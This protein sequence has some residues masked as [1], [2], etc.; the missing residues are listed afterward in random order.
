MEV[1]SVMIHGTDI[2][3][4]VRIIDKSKRAFDISVESTKALEMVLQKD[5][6][7]CKHNCARTKSVFYSLWIM[8]FKLHGA[9]P[10]ARLNALFM[11][12][13]MALAFELVLTLIFLIH[14]F[15]P[16]TSVWTIGFAYLF[17]LPG[18]TLIAP[19]WGLWSTVMGSPWMMKIWSTMNTTMIILNYPLTILMLWYVQDQV[20]YTAV[21]LLLIFNKMSLSFYG[22]KVRQHF[23]NPGYAKTLEKMQVTLAD[24]MAADRSGRS[25]GLTQAQRA[26]LLT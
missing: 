18:L 15:N 17:I 14:I 9:P 10:T 21:I 4:E 23:A 16:I 1:S 25:K 3:T 6:K 12:F 19:L 20:V 24:M 7:R 13:S 8:L 22:S 11:L 26:A 5:K 2:Q